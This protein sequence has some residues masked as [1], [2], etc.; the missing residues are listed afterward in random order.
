MN[1]FPFQ[2][3]DTYLFSF[4]RYGYSSEQALEHTINLLK[5]AEQN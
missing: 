4:N 5:E 3:M 2:A 1:L